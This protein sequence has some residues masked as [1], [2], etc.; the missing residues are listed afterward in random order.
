MIIFRYAVYKVSYA[1][2]SKWITKKWGEGYYVT[3]LATA[4]FRWG[5]MSCDALISDQVTII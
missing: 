2:P 3:A 5:V 4:G 1:F